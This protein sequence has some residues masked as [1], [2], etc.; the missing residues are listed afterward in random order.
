LLAR[1]GRFEDYEKNY[2]GENLKNKFGKV[3]NI[4]NQKLGTTINSFTGEYHPGTATWQPPAFADGRTVDQVY[5][6]KEWPFSVVSYKPRY[7][8]GG[9]LSN[10]PVLKGIQDT[11]AIEMNLEDA[12]VLGISTG[13]KVKLITPTGEAEGTAK[14]RRGVGKGSIAIEYGYGHWGAAGDKGYQVGDKKVAGD[15]KDGKGVLLNLLALRDVSLKE[16][17]PLSDLVGGSN[18]RNTVKARIVKL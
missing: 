8:T 16:V 11:N 9:Y 15:S 6:A 18:D 10:V 7:R 3:V 12:T 1:G 17:H 4:Y 5:P 2:E 14:V 13:D